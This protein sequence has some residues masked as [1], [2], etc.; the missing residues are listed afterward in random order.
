VST[1]TP[2]LCRTSSCPWTQVVAHNVNT[3]FCRVFP[4]TSAEQRVNAEAKVVG[5]IPGNEGVKLEP[6]DGYEDCILQSRRLNEFSTVADF[7]IS[8]PNINDKASCVHSGY[9]DVAGFSCRLLVYPAGNIHLKKFCGL[10]V[11]SCLCTRC[12]L[13]LVD[14]VCCPI[15]LYLVRQ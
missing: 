4:V 9:F 7:Q 8:I 3:Y 12:H 6:Q 14:C 2:P 15:S 1:V 5:M 11:A 10:E 13:Q